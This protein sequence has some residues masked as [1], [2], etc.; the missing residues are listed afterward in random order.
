MEQ[1][2]SCQ[3]P[4]FKTT[5]RQVTGHTIDIGIGEELSGLV[6]QEIKPIIYNGIL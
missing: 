3:S 4:N 6:T 5:R 2:S 1:R